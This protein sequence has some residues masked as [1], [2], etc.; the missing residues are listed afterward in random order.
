MEIFYNLASVPFALDSITIGFFDG[1]H[2][3]HHS[4]LSF[5]SSYSGTTGII[6][7]DTHPKEVLFQKSPKLI[8]NTQQRLSLLQKY[9]ISCLCMHP[10]TQEFANQ[11]AEDFI[12]FLHRH[13][14]CKRLI[15]GYDSTLGKE[16]KGTKATL[17][18][19]TDSL[20]I[21]LI[22]LPPY[23]VNQEVASSEKIRHLLEQGDLEK[24][25]QYLGY[26]YHYRGKVQTGCGLGQQL[27][28]ATINLPE[29]H[30]LL[31]HG[32]YACEIYT[33]YSGV[34]LGAMNLGIA[35]TTGRNSLC[36][37][38][39]LFDFSGDLYNT[40]VTI[41]PKKLLRKEQK[42]SS[43]QEL[44]ARIRQDI[45]RTKEYFSNYVKTT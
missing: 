11:S 7:F 19:L 33:E 44:S 24:A 37:E 28:V 2:L 21:E 18:P 35:P 8:T 17:K 34:Y 26:A 20:G 40:V 23:T 14:R 1:C 15:L 43:K 36:L 22:S 39:H 45:M 6:T 13:V 27:G 25:N 12:L 5:L 41:I 42:F 29:A 32:V 16:G 38:A 4:I 31:P 3:G 30:F 9:A 10:F